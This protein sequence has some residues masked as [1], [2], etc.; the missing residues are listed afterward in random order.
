LSVVHAA[1]VR[2]H[3]PED[4]HVFIPRPLEV[5]EPEGR[6]IAFV[7]FGVGHGHWNSSE[8]WR[9]PPYVARVAECT[10]YETI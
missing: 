7:M 1:D 6:S 10:V 4:P 8:R 3:L 9:K 2:V 5:C